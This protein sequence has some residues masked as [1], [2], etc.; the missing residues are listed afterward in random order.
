MPGPATGS[1]VPRSGFPWGRW[2]LCGLWLCLSLQTGLTATAGLWQ[3]EE[4]RLRVGLKIFPACLGAI[5]GLEARHSADGSLQVLV[6]YEGSADAA[7]DVA[8]SLG[9]I[10]K[11]HGLPLRVKT[12]AAATLDGYSELPVAGIFVASAGVGATRLKAWSER[13]Q[14]LV[15]SPFAGEVEAGAVAGI[16][17]AD[18][19]LP[20]IN[21]R[22]AQRAGV[23]FKPFFL[24]VARQ[25][26]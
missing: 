22:Q 13:F 7:Q 10:G 4:Q 5:D 14:A 20:F 1:R 18:Q 25:Y 2:L 21:P 19:V 24:K 16:A 23:R 9:G 15:F 11:I 17:V 8:F 6:V 12:V 26:E 3:E